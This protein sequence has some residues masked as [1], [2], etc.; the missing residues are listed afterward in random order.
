MY[1]QII[2]QHILDKLPETTANEATQ[3]L[4]TLSCHGILDEEVTPVE[5][6]APKK[7][8]KKV[9]K[10]TTKK[11]AKTTKKK[12]EPSTEDF[13]DVLDECQD[14]YDELCDKEIIEDMSIIYTIMKKH[15]DKAE[16]PDELSY[17]N[18]V[19]V[20]DELKKMLK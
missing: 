2:L 5:S 19:K 15:D 8:T 6:P 18:L 12:E 10:K 20:R 16:A 7:T 9:A 4:A 14:V 13:N 11:V 3:I 17:D 1:K